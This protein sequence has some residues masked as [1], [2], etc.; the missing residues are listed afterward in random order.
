M[1][2][3]LKVVYFDKTIRKV[4]VQNQY[5]VLYCTIINLKFYKKLN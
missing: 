4:F 5:V 1:L 3:L 2:Q